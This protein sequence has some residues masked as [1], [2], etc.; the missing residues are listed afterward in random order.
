M[1]EIPGRKALGMRRNGLV[2]AL[3]AGSL[4]TATPAWAAEPAQLVEILSDPTSIDRVIPAL[5]DTLR[6]ID[7]TIVRVFLYNERKRE[8]TDSL[9]NVVE[10]RL[11]QEL[12]RLRR[13]KVIESREAKTTRV[14]SDS[15]TFQ[16]SNTIES[17][18]RLR[19][20]GEAVGADSV[21]MYAPQ[22]QD[23]MVLVNAKMLRVSDGEVLWTE[24]FAYNFDLVKV[25]KE[26]AVKREAEEKAAAEKKRLADEHLTRDDGFYWGFVNV[27][28][29]AMRR[30]SQTD[31]TLDVV[32]YQSY[33]MTFTMLRSTPLTDN[34]SVGFDGE[35]NLLGMFNPDLAMPR[36][37]VGFATL[38]RL[39]PL[40][41]R[42]EN[43]GIFNLYFVPQL[44]VGLENGTADTRPGGRAGLMIKFRPDT[45][46][47]LG[48][49]YLDPHKPVYGAKAGYNSTLDAPLGGLTWAAGFG[50]VFK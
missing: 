10:N 46:L 9:A 17:I 34:F 14:Q 49:H 37:G 23:K 50:M 45:Y 40:W 31:P 20:I 12:L 48:C 41:V 30:Q 6:Q 2:G 3:V 35:V 43:Q 36:V 1:S 4:L 26:Q 15:K 24:R 29:F 28:G 38:L 47:T 25:L 22:I 7:P 39:D 5:P 8:E 32:T 11:Y 18:A 42:G 27:G 16:V 21:L 13:F 33:D 19:Q 44:T